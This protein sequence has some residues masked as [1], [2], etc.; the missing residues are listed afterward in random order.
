MAT[1]KDWKTLTKEVA[2]IFRKWRV[3]EWA[4]SP[5]KN[6]TPKANKVYAANERLV[7]LRFR[8]NGRWLGL[9]CSSES[10]ARDNLALLALAIESM[11]L[12]D[13]RKV[14][15]LVVGAYSSMYPPATPPPVR[16]GERPKV[17]TNDPYAILGVEPNY[18]LLVIEAVWKAHLRAVHPDMGGSTEKAQRLNAAMDAI[19]RLKGGV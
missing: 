11:R 2:E 3:T 10:F 1:S 16:E 8:K 19:R 17:D 7:T 13:V 15:K 5:E 9:G 6:P 14:T 18:P 4:I 12:N